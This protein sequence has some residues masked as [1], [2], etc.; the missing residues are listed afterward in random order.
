MLRTATK[1]KRN[2]EI[3][4]FKEKNKKERAIVLEKK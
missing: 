4:F 2:K 3:I 1:I